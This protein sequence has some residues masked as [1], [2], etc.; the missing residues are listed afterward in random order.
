M[1]KMILSITLILLLCLCSDSAAN[2]RSPGR[3]IQC[4]KKVSTRNFSED[5]EGT[6]YQIQSARKPCVDAI[7]FKI[8]YGMVCIDPKAAWVKEQIANMTVGKV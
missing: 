6:R 7:I 5:I 8:N 4:C 1:S 3:K 2:S